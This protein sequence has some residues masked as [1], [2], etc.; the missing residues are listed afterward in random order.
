M[1]RLVTIAAVT[2][3]LCLAQ[4]QEDTCLTKGYNE[5]PLYDIFAA[6]T[7]GTAGVLEIDDGFGVRQLRVEHV[8][9]NECD[10]DTATHE[11]GS[12]TPSAGLGLTTISMKARGTDYPSGAVG[13]AQQIGNGDCRI[14]NSTTGGRTSHWWPIQGLRVSFPGWKVKPENILVSDV[15]MEGHGEV[16]NNMR[17]AALVFG[18]GGID[19]NELFNATWSFPTGS[20]LIEHTNKIESDSLISPTGAPDWNLK[21]NTRGFGFSRTP[22]LHAWFKGIQTTYE[23][24]PTLPDEPL[25]CTT[26]AADPKCGAYFSFSNP[27]DGFVVLISQEWKSLYQQNGLISVSPLRI[28]C[29]C[30]CKT[31]DESGFERTVTL[32]TSTSG[33]CE[34]KMITD[35]QY[36][37]DETGDGWCS[38][39]E[40]DRYVITSN[41]V[42]NGLYPCEKSTGVKVQF[43][44]VF[45]SAN[46]PAIA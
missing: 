7:R 28:A 23:T 37:C 8:E 16:F 45:A 2:A 26:G 22:G 6:T 27:I 29:G 31:A 15:D 40:F 24:A 11:T 9:W 3:L 1:V 25:R 30:R 35:E 36:V 10:D 38:R 12:E 18:Y 32:P 33:M 43:E 21:S 14:N 39:K 4:A 42:T 20:G 41:E 5:Y 13:I 17:K 19:G 46:Y 34:R 44:N